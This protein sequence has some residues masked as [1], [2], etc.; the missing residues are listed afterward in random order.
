MAEYIAGLNQNAPDERESVMGAAAEL[1][2]IKTALQQTFP[3][4]DEALN[5]GPTELDAIE[6]RITA[7][8]SSWGSTSQLKIATGDYDIAENG[9]G[10]YTTTGL[11]FAPQH[12]LLVVRNNHESIA[13][14][15]LSM[16]TSED[17]EHYLSVS[18]PGA[19]TFVNPP[20]TDG[21]VRLPNRMFQ[22]PDE[23]LMLG[24]PFT[25]LSDGFSIEYKINFTGFGAMTVMWVAFR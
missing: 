5:I 2:G 12:V 22:N 15:S 10:L 9:A 8:E 7:M 21:I 20:D 17:G 1:R 23:E 16:A 4:Y 13:E 3:N 18:N 14:F 11:G 24:D 19:S 6:N 25:F